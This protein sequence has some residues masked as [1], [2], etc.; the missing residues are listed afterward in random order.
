MPALPGGGCSR[1]AG[2]A[3]GASR[4]IGI[5]RDEEGDGMNAHEGAPARPE[6]GPERRA[7]PFAPGARALVDAWLG[8]S[9]DGAA[10]LALAAGDPLAAAV[11]GGPGMRALAESR[12]ADALRWARSR[13]GSAAKGLVGA[14]ALIAGGRVVAG[15]EELE[16]LARRRD[17]A[18]TLALARR[19]HLLGDHAR[20]MAAA[21]R[22]PHHPAAALIGARSALVAGRAGSALASLHPF[23]GGEVGVV[24]PVQTGAIGAVAAAALARLGKA[25]ELGAFARRLLSQGLVP[26]EMLPG[27]ARVGWTAGLVAETRERLDREPGPWRDAARLELAILG[28][29]PERAAAEAAA[30]GPLA[31]PSRGLLELLTGAKPGPGGE[32]A[33]LA[34]ARLIEIWRTHPT[35]WAPWIEAVKAAKA[36]GG[37]VRIRDLA[38]G[39]LPPGDA[40]APDLVLD[41]GA[42]VDLVEPVPVP[43]RPVD[44]KG[45]WVEPGLCEGVGIGHDWPPLERR[46]LLRGMRLAVSPDT[47]HIR[48]AGADAALGRAAEGRREIVIAPPGDP[49]WAGPVPERAWP[50][51]HVVRADPERGWTGAGARTAALARAIAGL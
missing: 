33:V 9:G 35:R 28:G 20:A 45:I 34:G 29:D 36:A 30:A 27:L 25:A 4:A 31:E 49:F 40:P 8:R 5:G 46:A 39:V 16:R 14:E 12:L 15:L 26:P 24:D 48:V 41:D 50:A 51:M 19:C 1:E 21:S 42:L 44:G 3:A 32:R 17:P 10:A 7:A 22:L 47:A 13:P 2:E 23:L 37:G 38:A 6:G 11:L 18:G 43:A